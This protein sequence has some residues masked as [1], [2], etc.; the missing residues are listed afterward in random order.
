VHLSRTR[1]G[2]ARC[3]L[4]DTRVRTRAVKGRRPHR[5]HS[6]VRAHAHTIS[7][8]RVRAR[9]FRAVRPNDVTTAATMSRSLHAGSPAMTQ[10]R[11]SRSC[12][13]PTARGVLPLVNAGQGGSRI[14]ALDRGREAMGGY[15]IRALVRARARSRSR[16]WQPAL[17]LFVLRGRMTL[18]SRYPCLTIVVCDIADGDSIRQKRSS[19]ASE[20]FFSHMA[21]V[22]GCAA[23]PR[24]CTRPQPASWPEPSAGTPRRSA[25]PQ[26]AS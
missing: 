17:A 23:T 22:H 16:R 11:R 10:M 12:P 5:I 6:L 18:T 3:P 15:R 13:S 24:R 7:A 2:T 4:S 20:I 25:R 19:T 9:P 14:L 8:M 26:P 1:T 21:H